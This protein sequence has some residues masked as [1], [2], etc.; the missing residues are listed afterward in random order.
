M[1]GLP[2][3]GPC[4]KGKVKPAAW[5]RAEARAGQ[6]SMATGG[7]AG[8]GQRTAP[9]TSQADPRARSVRVTNLASSHT[10]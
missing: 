1:P 7:A 5:L 4:P 9:V 8:R 2:D 10:L 6:V 3:A